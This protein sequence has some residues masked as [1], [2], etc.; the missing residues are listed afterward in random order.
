M[1]YD[2]G[3]L[4]KENRFLVMKTMITDRV[5]VGA[6]GGVRLRSDTLSLFESVYMILVGTENCV[7]NIMLSHNVPLYT[8]SGL[9][10]HPRFHNLLRNIPN[11]PTIRIYF[12]ILVDFFAPFFDGPA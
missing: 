9:C 11:N 3:A 12:H 10:T 5:V 8:R 2:V 6:M 4:H 7:T 1:N